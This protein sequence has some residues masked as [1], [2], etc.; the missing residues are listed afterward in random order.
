[1]AGAWRRPL[2]AAI[3]LGPVLAM[4]GEY[5]AGADQH[6]TVE[7]SSV[8]LDSTDEHVGETVSVCVTVAYAGKDALVVRVG[9][10]TRT[11]VGVEL[12]EPVAAG[13]SSSTNQRISWP[14]STGAPATS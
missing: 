5:A 12:P 14:S 3:L 1:M 11:V 6:A 4:A 10:T 7:R 8:M 9:M 2:A 13:C